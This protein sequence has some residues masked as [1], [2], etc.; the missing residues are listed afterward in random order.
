MQINKK[1]KAGKSKQSNILK[2]HYTRRGKNK[3]KKDG[4]VLIKDGDF[5]FFSCKLVMLVLNGKEST[6][7]RAM[8]FL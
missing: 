6:C 3:K 7:R 4:S 2:I 8:G 1:M 5:F